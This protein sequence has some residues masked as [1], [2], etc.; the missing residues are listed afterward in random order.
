[1][2]SSEAWR[3]VRTSPSGVLGTIDPDVGVHLVPVVFTVVGDSHVLVAVDS[4]PKRSRRLRRLENIEADPR[5]TL[6]VDHY[7][8][9]WSRLWWVR[10][11]GRASVRSS[12]DAATERAHRERYPQL[13]GHIL[14]PWI[15]IA[16]DH[17]SGWSAT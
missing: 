15:D 3:R 12:V 14:G 13:D 9:D 8:D 6:L 1:V 7:T 10:L 17:V 11:E 4:K 2:D 16:V 5:V